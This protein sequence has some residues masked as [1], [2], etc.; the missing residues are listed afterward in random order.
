MVAGAVDVHP[1]KRVAM[2]LA[3]TTSGL[4]DVLGK[5]DNVKYIA[6]KSGYILGMRLI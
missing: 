6:P 3:N 4:W 2:L 1:P 5:V